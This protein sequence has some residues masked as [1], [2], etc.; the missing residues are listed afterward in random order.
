[1]AIRKIGVIGA[2]NM[3][4]ALLRG[5][6]AS[7]WSRKS[8]VLASHPKKPKATALAR[9]LGIRVFG[10]NADQTALAPDRVLGS[11][12]IDLPRAFMLIAREVREGRFTPRV[13]SFGLGS[14]VIRYAP[15]PALD[16]LLSPD[17]KEKLQAAQDSIIAGTLVP[18]DRSKGRMASE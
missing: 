6:L 9:E 18:V 4:T 1:M 8:N 11:A 7:E 15:N 5:I 13:E 14:G 3:G 10:S 12:V 17:L 2:G 16:S